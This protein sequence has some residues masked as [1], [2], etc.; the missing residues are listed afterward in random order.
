M[1]T[2]RLLV[3]HGGFLYDSD[4]YNDELPYWNRV[5]DRPHLVVP[6]GLINNDAKFIRGGMATGEDFFAFLRDAAGMLLREGATAPK[7]MSVGLHLRVTGHPGRAGAVPGLGRGARRAMALPPYRRCTPFGGDPPGARTGL[8]IEHQIRSPVACQATSIAGCR[9]CG[10]D[11]E[12]EAGV[13][14][15]QR[16]GTEGKRHD[17]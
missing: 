10:G 7:M 14:R 17:G 1:N 3:K 6:Y 5:A 2:R 13:K 4:A 16:S 8:A 11:K 9:R 12:G 15:P